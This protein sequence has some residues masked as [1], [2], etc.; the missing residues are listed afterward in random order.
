MRFT[1]ERIRTLVLVAGGLLVVVLV[2]F[3]AIGKWKHRFISHDLPKRLGIDIQ[4][5]ANGFTH[6]EFRAGKALFKITASRVEQLKNDHFRLH[7]VTIE[8]YGADGRSV[9]RIQGNEFEYD[10]KA[11]IAQAAGPVEITLSRLGDASGMLQGKAQA[12]ALGGMPK[13]SPL[14]AAVK[15][16]KSGEIQVK[17][18]G[19]T[20]N[21][22]TGTAT[23]AQYLEFALAQGSGS[24]IGA[25]YDSQNGTLVFDRAVQMQTRH[26]NDLVTLKAAHGQYDR[27]DQICHLND[28]TVAYRDGTAQAAQAQVA[29]RDDGSADRLDAKQF[30][31]TT[32]A[33]D[34]LSAPTAT[35]LF[36]AH[37][38]PS[39]GHLEGGVAMDDA[40]NG[41]TTHGTAP[42]AELEFNAKG[43][44]H[45]AHLERGVSIASDEQTGAAHVHRQWNSPVADLDFHDAGR[46]Q[47][48][49]ASIHG[50]GGVTV[51]S[52]T[53]RGAEP[54]TPDRFA[55]DEV[56]GIF[57]ANSALTAMTGTGH[58]HMEQTAQDGTRQTTS[59]DRLD[60]HMAAQNGSR[61]R[62]SAAQIDSAIV[63]GNVTLVQQPAAKPGAAAPAELRAMA[64]R[65]VYEGAGQWL[66]LFGSPRV[67]DGSL[68]LTAAKIDVAQAT[69]DAFAHGNVKATWFGAK[70]ASGQSQPLGGQGPAHIVAA[71]AQLH[72]ATGEAA[73][74]GQARLWQGA[75]SISAPA[76]VLDR[77]RRTLTAHAA[78]PGDPVRVVM[79]SNGAADTPGKPHASAPSV[80][81]VRGG[82]LKY[83]DAERKAV[84]WGG[85]AGGVV[86]ETP[87][88]TTRA[89][90]VELVLLPP[91]NHAGPNGGAAQVD[92]MTARGHVVIESQGRR[93]SGEQLS[94]SG[95]TG[96]YTLTGTAAAP[97]RMTDPQR[98]VITGGA[99]I[100]NSR[101]DSVNVE[102]GGRATSAE[103]TV[104]RRSR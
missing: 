47:M 78:G 48:E 17:T 4:Q 83:S 25:T 70:S 39:H 97:P 27:D 11:G 94:Y 84:M 1:I 54:A 23:T 63:T 62:S 67:E 51:A 10:Q 55:A 3:L 32:A 50:T 57:G 90:E 79:L 34:H 74:Q 46:G 7:S 45:R 36:D 92:R 19:L 43:E 64:E 38:Q 12:R 93:G 76:I 21:Q 37:N 29:F 75:N 28:A 14:A 35:L 73:F 95:E 91:G 24:A 85:A 41:R 52:E 16:A 56:T 31:L 6:A 96:S 102:G 101:D 89:S 66:H 87:D 69:G 65:A 71:E 98:G 22:K 88:A 100:F 86:A 99:L 40:S 5:E 61:S 77:D 80:V 2:A 42:S 33:G 53:R 103:T 8:M 82:D 104:P 26:G 44:L 72:K 58:A 15:D 68:Q 13:N 81:R 60:V 49:L 18:S 59:G 9:D 20:F 30:A